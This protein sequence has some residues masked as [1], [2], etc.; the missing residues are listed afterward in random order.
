LE[1]DESE[2]VLKSHVDSDDTT[3]VSEVDV[4]RCDDSCQVGIHPGYPRVSRG[5]GWLATT[6]RVQPA[7]D[8]T[9][10]TVVP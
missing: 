10:V 5:V 2:A 1:L 6:T 3:A 4:G 9:T 7:V 8:A